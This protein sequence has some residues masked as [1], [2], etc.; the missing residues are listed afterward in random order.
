MNNYRRHLEFELSGIWHD[1]KN[2][3]IN[4]ESGDR[5]VVRRQHSSLCELKQVQG[6]IEYELFRNAEECDDWYDQ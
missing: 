1:I 3:K 6:E 2:T 5:E 4:Y